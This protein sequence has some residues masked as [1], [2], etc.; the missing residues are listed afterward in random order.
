MYLNRAWCPDGKVMEMKKE[1]VVGILAVQT[2]IA[3]AAGESHAS[4]ASEHVVRG[5][6]YR[7]Q[8]HEGRKAVSIPPL[9][10]MLNAYDAW[11]AARWN[12][13]RAN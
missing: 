1:I 2:L 9:T 6:A 11:E 4:C 3:N 7:E 8:L 10:R 5:L 13:S 12:L